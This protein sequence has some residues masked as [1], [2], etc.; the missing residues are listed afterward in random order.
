MRTV[1][2]RVAVMLSSAVFT[3][4]LASPPVSAAGGSIVVNVLSDI[5]ADDGTCS[6]REA[7]E[8]SNSNTASGASPG[9]C[10][11][12]V[13]PDADSITFAVSGTITLG[14]PLQSTGSLVVDG[15]DSITIDGGGFIPLVVLPA[16]TVTLRKLAIVHGGGIYSEGALTLKDVTVSDSFGSAGGGIDSFGS[17]TMEH[18]AVLSNTAYNFGG[19]V[20]IEKGGTAAISDSTIASNH[21]RYGGGGLYNE[22]SV[23]LI[24]STV[25]ANTS[26]FAAVENHGEL[27]I[28]N[29]TITLNRATSAAGIFNAGKLVAINSTISGNIADERAGGLVADGDETI[30]NTILAGNVAPTDPE[31]QDS[32]ESTTASLV[33]L[34]AGVTLSQILDPGGPGMNGGPT[35]TIALVST[36]SNPAIDTGHAGTCR[37]P[38]ISG[39]D[40]RGVARP[41]GA[42]DIGAYEAVTATITSPPT[43][44]SMAAMAGPPSVEAGLAVAGSVVMAAAASLVL[45]LMAAE[46]GRRPR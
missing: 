44:V 4:A 34:P 29:S 45:A 39:V 37:A 43:D 7:V 22:G 6:L 21:T 40:Q 12:G 23:A 15:G 26:S 24:R 28:A 9:E 10:R 31:V 14:Y 19:G 32:I 46:R 35:R 3:L 30:V 11:A 16:S 42:C 17:L 25:E 8:A 1:L 41:K 5:S 18:S 38:P 27:L 20:S 2:A 13:T 33:G 36:P